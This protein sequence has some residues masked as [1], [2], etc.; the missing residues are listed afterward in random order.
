MSRKR[1]SWSRREREEIYRKTNGRCAY[2]GRKISFEEMSCDHMVSLHNHGEDSIENMAPSCRDC[3]LAKKG[4]NVEGFRKRLR[5][6]LR[7]SSTGVL[8]ARLK[9]LYGGER[10]SGVFLIDE[11]LSLSMEN[12][13]RP[14]GG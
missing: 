8:T 6:M 11:I 1:H 12:K 2:C 4:C 14:P 10:W 7:G 9:A 5:K 3:N 13:G